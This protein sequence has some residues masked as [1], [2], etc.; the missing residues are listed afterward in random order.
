MSFVACSRATDYFSGR[1]QRGTRMEQRGC[2]GAVR[3]RRSRVAS[4]NRDGPTS[5]I[6]A[7][8]LAEAS[9]F[10]PTRTCACGVRRLRE[11]APVGTCPR[12]LARAPTIVAIVLWQRRWRRARRLV[13]PALPSRRRCCR[14]RSARI[15]DLTAGGDP[16]ATRSSGPHERRDVVGFVID[17]DVQVSPLPRVVPESPHH[18]SAVTG[19]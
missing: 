12:P 1:E 9:T 5:L 3:R 10:G 4:S 6:S 19:A 17:A 18:S 13:P 7:T 16:T 15:A 8:S 14:R 11:C 2:T